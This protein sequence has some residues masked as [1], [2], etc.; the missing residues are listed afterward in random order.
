MADSSF[1]SFT[2]SGQPSTA[3]NASSDVIQ[4]PTNVQQGRKYQT[5]VF[6]ADAARAANVSILGSMWATGPFVP[7]ATMA[8]SSTVP[9]GGAAYTDTVDVLAPYRFLRADVSGIAGT[10]TSV[11]IASMGATL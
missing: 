9:S 11:Q 4:I 5:G 7:L 10:G 2:F 3:V 8:A 6:G 1:V